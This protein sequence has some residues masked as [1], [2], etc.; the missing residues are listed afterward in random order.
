[1]ETRGNNMLTLSNLPHNVGRMTPNIDHLDA[2]PTSQVQHF[3]TRPVTLMRNDAE[4][5]LLSLE[6]KFWKCHRQE[7]S[8]VTNDHIGRV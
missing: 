1:M 6:L 8:R 7:Q 2:R 4:P 3:R 5:E